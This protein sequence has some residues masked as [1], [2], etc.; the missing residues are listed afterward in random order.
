MIGRFAGK[1]IYIIDLFLGFPEVFLL[2]YHLVFF[3]PYHI[4]KPVFG[5]EAVT[6][7]KDC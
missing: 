1:L 5:N 4:K 6:G 7:A 2:F 3:F